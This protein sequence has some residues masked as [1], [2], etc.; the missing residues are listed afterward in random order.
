M[1]LRS[2]NGDR[3]HESSNRYGFITKWWTSRLTGVACQG[4][5]VL[6]LLRRVNDSKAAYIARN[7][8]RID[9]SIGGRM[10]HIHIRSR[11]TFVD[12]LVNNQ[13]R[14]KLA[15][16]PPW[17]P[18]AFTVALVADVPP[19]LEAQKEVKLVAPRSVAR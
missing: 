15:K 10:F 14:R 8:T 6:Q 19:A 16:I 17:V 18:L 11:I 2:R 13:A 4:H 12:P 3:A 9:A 1:A 7:Q 5:T